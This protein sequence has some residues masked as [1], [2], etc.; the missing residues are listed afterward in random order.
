[1]LVIRINTNEGLIMQRLSDT[2]VARYG[3]VVTVINHN[4]TS[5][6]DVFP[7]SMTREGVAAFIRLARDMGARVSYR[8][9]K[10]PLPE[11][12]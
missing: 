2:S 6:T 4:G 7:G 3:Y 5:Y 8:L 9:A 10:S 12:A 1:M 11:Y